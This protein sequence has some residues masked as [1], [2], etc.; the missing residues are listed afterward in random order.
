MKLK[1]DEAGHVVVQDDKPVYVHDDGKEIP[2]DAAGTIRAIND[3]GAEN[4]KIREA[5]EALERQ[6][7]AFDGLDPE[8]ARKALETF[9]A[10]D[11]KKLI[12][13][14]EVERVKREAKEAFDRQFAESYKPLEAERDQLKA[15]LYS[16]RLGT[17]FSRSK[18]LAEKVETPLDLIQA[19]FG[20]NFSIGDDGKIVARGYD[21]NPLFSRA[22]PGD[23][24]DFEEAIEMLIASHPDRDRMLR[25]TGASGG[26]GGPYKGGGGGKREIA[27]SEFDKMSPA[28]KMTTALAAGTGEVKIV[29]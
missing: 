22:K 9:D 6:F 16:E 29:D 12:D 7:K 25:G 28:E 8:K 23:A 21:G 14:G 17:A 19:R 26:G 11:A 20:P 15:Q 27:K 1:L 18:Y 13:A 10:L 2:F 5:K 3:R 4:K 24:P